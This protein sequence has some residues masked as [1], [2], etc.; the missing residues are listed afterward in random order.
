MTEQAIRTTE[1]AILKQ[2]EDMTERFATLRQELGNEFAETRTTHQL[3]S[4][5]VGF[6]DGRGPVEG[7]PAEAKDQKIAMKT[8]AAQLTMSAGT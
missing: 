5:V 6:D 1:M 4:H 3:T 2:Q 7:A 8:D